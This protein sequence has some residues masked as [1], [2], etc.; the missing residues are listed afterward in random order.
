MTGF[1]FDEETIAEI[2]EAGDVNG[3]GVIQYE[4]YGDIMLGILSDAYEAWEKSAK[5]EAPVV[6]DATKLRLDDFT[7]E[8]LEI[9]F[10]RLFAI[11]DADGSGTLDTEEVAELLSL[12]G[13]QFEQKMVV[14]VVET[15]DTNEDGLIQY[16]EFV[17][18]MVGLIGATS[19]SAAPKKQEAKGKLSLEDFSEEDLDAYFYRLF[20][21]ADTDGNGTLE[22]E[23]VAELLFLSGFSFDE[24]TVNKVMMAADT[25]ED[26]VIQYDE[27]VP[28]MLGILDAKDPAPPPCMEIGK[29]ASKDPLLSLSTYSDEHLTVYFKQLFKL[30]DV[31]NDGVLQVS[32]VEELLT[33][34]G[35][36][37][38]KE[39]VRDLINAADTNEDGVIQYEEFVPM[40][41]GAIAGS[42]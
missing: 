1:N 13:F 6:E 5:E 2:I 23:E 37:F 16:E 4:E 11:A 30:G 31:N 17:P 34:C 41:L 38:S 26:G 9:Y 20:M 29:A 19:R 27:F 14:K 24:E 32:E 12:T 18:M 8:E 7:D 39:L 33:M 40:M 3:D 42:Q 25:N 36:S 21:I 28:M 15:A 10:H 35:F 22:A